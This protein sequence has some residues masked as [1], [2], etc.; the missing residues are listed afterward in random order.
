MISNHRP[1]KIKRKEEPPPTSDLL[2]FENM[3]ISHQ[4]IN[5][6]ISNGGQKGIQ[7]NDPR[8]LL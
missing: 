5:E 2:K 7:E 4:N 6:I 1:I 3:W 8:F